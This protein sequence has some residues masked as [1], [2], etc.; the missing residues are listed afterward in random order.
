MSLHHQQERPRIR[1]RIVELGLS[2]WLEHG[3]WDG[4]CAK[5]AEGHNVGLSEIMRSQMRLMIREGYWGDAL[6]MEHKPRYRGPGRHIKYV[7]GERVYMSD[8]R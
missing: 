6:A 1:K 4:K 3:R 8:G 7:N 2:P 5:D